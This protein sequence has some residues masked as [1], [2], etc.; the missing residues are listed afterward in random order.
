MDKPI[1][2]DY[3]ATTPVDPRVAKKM[4]PY[5]TDVFGNAAS[6]HFYG[7]QAK[8]AIEN[9]R[10][11]VA[12]LLNTDP[13]N[14]IW[15][16]GATEANNLAIKGI[17]YFYQHQ[18]NHIVT[19]K[20]EHKSVLDIC[21]YLETQGFKVTYLTPKPDGLIDLY[22][23]EQ[24]LRPETILASIMHVNNEIGVIQDIAAIGDLLRARGVLLHVDATQSVGKLPIDLQKLKVDLISFSGHKIYGPKGVG[25]LYLRPKL[26]LVPQIHGGQQEQGI[27]SGTLATQQIVG[28]GEALHIASQE[29]SQEYKRLLR[30][31]QS[32]WQELQNLDNVYLNGSLT[33]RIAGNLNI[34]FSDIDGELLLA[35]LQDL[36]LS[37]AAACTKAVLEPSHV[38]K[39][40]DV[41]HNLA[42][43]TIRISLG[44]FTS[45]AEIDFTIKY[46]KNTVT[47]LRTK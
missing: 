9:A 11:Q 19:C 6:F 4:Q 29:M 45:A 15:T 35:A 18:G 33:Q 23:L 47:K 31:H 28:M 25:A 20:T 46:I 12:T 39:A 41:P 30:L 2:L 32:L 10:S 34:S 40:L 1:Y 17:M 3:M 13:K 22:T 16:S 42:L 44:R 36:A 26:H 38:L 5:L 8:T 7:H 43:N 37:T 27:R 21:K 14:I 24:A